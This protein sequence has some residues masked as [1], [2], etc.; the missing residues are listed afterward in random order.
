MAEKLP[1]ISTVRYTKYLPRT[2]TWVKVDY[3]DL[4]VRGLPVQSRK[5]FDKARI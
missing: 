1:K 2:N 4:F 5:K 3:M